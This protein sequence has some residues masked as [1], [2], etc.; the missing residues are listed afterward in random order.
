MNEIAVIYLNWK[1]SG[2]GPVGRFLNSYAAHPAGVLHD[3]ILH[4]FQSGFDIHAYMRAGW[5]LPHPFLCC[6]N[7]ETE[8]RSDRWLAKMFLAMTSDTG[9]VGAFASWEGCPNGAPKFPNPHIRTNGFLIRKE[10]FLGMSYP[11]NTKQGCYS[12]ESGMNS[13]TRRMVEN[14]KQVALVGNDGSVKY[15]ADWKDTHTFRQHEQENLLFHDN[16]SRHYQEAGAQE[17][18][19]LTELAW[20][21]A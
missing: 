17:R 1:P 18:Q 21:K 20:G 13:M 6:L 10:L 2:G 12:F 3:L 19:R 5:A 14:K 7:T 16:Q 8:I 4:E 15:A 9:L 11:S